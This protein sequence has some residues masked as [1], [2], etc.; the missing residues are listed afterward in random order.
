MKPSGETMVE[1]P[2]RLLSDV[3]REEYVRLHGELPKETAQ[4]LDAADRTLREATVAAK[5]DET[6]VKAARQA[7][8]T[9]KLK[10][11]YA[12][13]HKLKEDRTALCFSGGGIRSATFA[14]GVTQRLAHFGL[15]A[16]FDFLSTVSGG[17]YIGSWLSSFVRRDPDGMKSVQYKI[18]GVPPAERKPLEPEVE[19]LVWLRRFSNYLTPKLG[20]MSA[21][22]WAFVG[23][24][25]RNLL[26]VWLVFVPFL[27]AVLAL[28]RLGI[29]LLRLQ[30]PGFNANLTRDIAAVLLLFGTIV[31]AASRPVSYRKKGRLTNDRFLKFV[32][33]PYVAGALLLA[34]YWAGRWIPKPEWIDVQYG[35]VGLIGINVLSSLAYMVK[36][37]IELK[38]QRP[39]NI[40]SDSTATKYVLKKL[41]WEM[42]AAIVAGATATG[43]LYA[44]GA[45][46]FNDPHNTVAPLT[47][48]TWQHLPPALAHADAEMY[49]C[50]ALP[51]VLGVFFAQSAIFVAL[52]SWFNEEYDREW[53]GRAAGWVLLAAVAWM[54]GTAITIYG[55]VAVYF[56]PR[57]YAALT[58]GTGLAAILLGK[59]GATGATEQEKQEKAGPVQTGATIGLAV[60]GPLFAI[61]LLALISLCTSLI[62]NAIDP[63]ERIK[64]SEIAVRAAGTYQIREA[65]AFDPQND[66]K[67][68]RTAN[69]ETSRFPAIDET[70]IAAN[71]HLLAVDKTTLKQGLILV[72]GLVG[73]SWIISFFIGANQF[74]LHGLY[75]NRL[76]RGYLGA[77]N[78]NR[79]PNAFTGFDPTD[80]LPMDRLRPEMFL[81]ST[82][83]D[84][85]RDGPKILREPGLIFDDRTKD[86]VTAAV[87]APANPELVQA[88]RDLLSEDLNR[89]IDN[90]K[91][92]LATA[93]QLPQSVANRRELERRLPDAFGLMKIHERPLHLVNT[94][95]NLVAGDDLAWQE[96]KGAAFG[97]SPLYSGNQSL[98][99]RATRAYGGP[100][101]VSLGTAVAVS[102][103]AASPN[104][105][106]N[107]SPA[108]S[109]LLTLFNVRLGWWFGNPAKT[110]YSNRNPSNTLKTVLDEAF[111]LTDEKHNYVYLSDGAHFDN[112]GLYEMIL[113][114]CRCIVVSDAGADPEFGFQDLGNAIRKIRIDL[115]V[116]IEIKQMALFPRSKKD[117]SNPKYCAVASIDYSQVDGD[118][119]KPGLLLYLKPAFY[120]KD[121]PKDVYNYATTYGSFPHQSTGDQWFSE[122][123]F[124]SYRQLGFFAAGEVAM[125]NKSFTSVCDF[126]KAA[127]VYI[128]L[129]GKTSGTGAS[130]SVEGPNAGRPEGAPDA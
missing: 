47:V 81:P 125:G 34:V 48:K 112:L 115:G 12:D 30:T 80:N 36:Y 114:R 21:D 103:A 104:M 56:A 31:V 14:L 122:S 18:K 98:G 88:A 11:L 113:R 76:V 10:A 32:L 111:G 99:Y 118:D 75:R 86:A 41:G 35:L 85:V 126:I 62:L 107:S 84:V 7:A 78:S 5:G 121:E 117:P 39:R 20:L 95:L 69:F 93:G 17:G 49:L 24:Y 119:V 71:E 97:I 55:P 120:G 73:F 89:C 1:E 33:L 23:S 65:K 70:H 6:L 128:R 53:W 45:K 26:L 4:V 38:R 92:V 82:I 127:Q 22:T 57:I 63:P 87:A 3:L 64:P 19:P 101:G 29:A 123:Q 116:N 40:R 42:V 109:F 110:T 74:S 90:P 67:T 9:V 102:G 43:L 15:L 72:F 96:R 16:K 83:K 52:S 2:L 51:L 59:G 68:E 130:R 94:T 54:V 46:L 8:E 105:G 129:E 77:S 106:Y 108:L 50:F 44:I 124:E 13:I 28:P 100:S 61:A 37:V 27:A 25:L 91:V 66:S 79:L 60:A 58:A